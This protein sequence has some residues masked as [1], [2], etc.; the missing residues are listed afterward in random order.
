MTSVSSCGLLAAAT[1]PQAFCACNHFP[2]AQR[3]LQLRRVALNDNYELRF[4]CCGQGLHLVVWQDDKE[5]RC[6]KERPASVKNLIDGTVEALGRSGLLLRRC[7]DEKIQ[8]LVKKSEIGTITSQVLEN[9]L[10][11]LAAGELV[12]HEK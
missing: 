6:R 8:V 10:E 3:E 2:V 5:V 12:Q 9:A 1:L 11:L 4:Y 7:G